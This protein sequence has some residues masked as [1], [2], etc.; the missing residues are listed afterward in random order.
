MSDEPKTWQEGYNSGLH[1]SQ[2]SNSE[3]W[4]G[5][6]NRLM[7]ENN[8]RAEAERQEKANKEWCE[9][10]TSHTN[11]ASHGRSTHSS[12]VGFVDHSG[13]F[14]GGGAAGAGFAFGVVGLIIFAFLAVFGYQK[15]EGYVDN[16]R[17]AQRNQEQAD[18]LA[19]ENQTRAARHA[20]I[21][22]ATASTWDDFE[23]LCSEQVRQKSHAQYTTV[24]DVPAIN[25]C[26]CAH[27][28]PNMGS[29]C[30]IYR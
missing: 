30:I 29:A 10:L 28:D 18:R 9:R 15:Y 13:S 20:I 6:N 26:R 1:P 11:N 25:R 7:G 16:Q 17:N 19:S 22:F 8:N 12:G 4:C 5:A 14:S 2:V 24:R 3:A 27:R 23:Y 21:T